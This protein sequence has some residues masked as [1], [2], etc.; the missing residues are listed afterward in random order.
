MV[1]PLGLEFAKN[2]LSIGENIGK[3]YGI[4]RYPQKVGVGWLVSPNFLICCAPCSA[5]TVHEQGFVLFQTK[6]SVYPSVI[7]GSICPPSHSKVGITAEN[8]VSS[9]RRP[10][11]DVRN[12]CN[13]RSY[14]WQDIPCPGRLSHSKVGITAENSVSS[15]WV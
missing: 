7:S 13:R 4:I 9:R 14:R 5:Q 11:T 12:C 8:S 1:T 3:V 2:R 15:R 6:L 10:G